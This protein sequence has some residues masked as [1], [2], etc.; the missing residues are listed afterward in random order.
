MRAE[1]EKYG[2][3]RGGVPSTDQM[4]RN[5]EIW[6]EWAD[7]IRWREIGARF[8]LSESGAQAIVKRIKHWREHL[9]TCDDA[10]CKAVGKSDRS[11][12]AG[13]HKHILILGGLPQGRGESAALSSESAAKS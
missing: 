3:E 4:A 1:A 11:Y 5:S 12:F 13:A 7:G 10:P 6:R 9:L 2:A 8:V